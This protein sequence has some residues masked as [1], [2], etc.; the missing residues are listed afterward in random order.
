MMYGMVYQP[1]LFPKG[2]I[3][4]LLNL[5]IIIYIMVYQPLIT[6]VNNIHEN[7]PQ[8]KKKQ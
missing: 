8:T 4:Q 3:M 2:L 1:R 6:D 5:D 7:Q